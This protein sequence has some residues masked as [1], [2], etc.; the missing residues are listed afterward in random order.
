MHGVSF[1]TQSLS[2]AD[3]VM[4]K[5]TREGEGGQN[6]TERERE[7]GRETRPCMAF[8]SSSARN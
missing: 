3:Y 6:K 1:S 4:T 2:G 7:G 8:P 5:W